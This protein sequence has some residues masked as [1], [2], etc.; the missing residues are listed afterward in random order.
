MYLRKILTLAAMAVNIAMFAQTEATDTV[1]VI[2]DAKQLIIQKDNA[3]NSTI[4]LRALKIIAITST[5]YK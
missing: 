3:G 4:T 2:K 5:N 1:K